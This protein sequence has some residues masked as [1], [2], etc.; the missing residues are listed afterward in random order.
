MRRKRKFSSE[1]VKS[2]LAKESASVRDLIVAGPA[3]APLARAKK[4]Y[5][6]QIMLRTRQ[7]AQLGQVLT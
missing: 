2:K 1:F 3:P 4:D 7:I 5:R 6:Y